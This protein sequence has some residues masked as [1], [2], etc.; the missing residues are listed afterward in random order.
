MR[1]H[2]KG[3][4][5]IELLVVIAIIAILAAI[6]FPVF[7]QA[8][9]AARKA[10]CSSNL[11]Q[12]GYAWLMYAQDYDEVTVIVNGST[13]GTV[14][15][16][17]ENS[18]NTAT[19]Q[20]DQMGGLLQPYMKNAKV[21]DCPSATGIPVLLANSVAYGRNNVP[22][23]GGLP[24]ALPAIEA[25]ADTIILADNAFRMISTTNIGNIGRSRQIRPPSLHLSSTP[26]AHGRHHGLANVLWFDG[27]VKATKVH[28]RPN[29][30][31][32]NTNETEWHK[33]NNIGDLLH[34]RCPLG[35]SCQDYYFLPTKP[36]LP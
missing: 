7:A 25:P 32:P 22:N 33:S 3:F 27:H 29:V 36:A 5:L 34:P 10:S 1:S 4:T 19:G 8:R 24:V 31:G 16:F 9:E 20:I 17:W 23:V 14:S 6:L 11:K 2:S 28:P 26:T 35:S 12:I 15:Y 21:L 18:F 30:V 13:I